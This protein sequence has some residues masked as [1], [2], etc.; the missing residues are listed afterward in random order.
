VIAN[1]AA[2]RD[3]VRR[4]NSSESMGRA[5]VCQAPSTPLIAT[6]SGSVV[7]GRARPLSHCCVISS[8][9]I[10]KLS[11]LACRTKSANRIVS[12]ERLLFRRESR[13]LLPLMCKAV[14]RDF[15]GSRKSPCGP[16]FTHEWL[17][18]PLLTRSS[19]KEEVSCRDLLLSL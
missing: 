5:E 8:T 11:V 7:G 6:L 16:R 14:L 13:S 19:R 1:R 2:S 18:T 4:L 3:R 17:K 15:L 9:D 12:S 10:H